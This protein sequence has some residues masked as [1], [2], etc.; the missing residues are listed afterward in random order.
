MISVLARSNGFMRIMVVVF[1]RLDCLMGMMNTMLTRT[2]GLVGAVTPTL[3]RA[4]VVFSTKIAGVVKL[5]IAL[6]Q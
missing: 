3:H 4:S 5:G 1:S 2:K 6:L